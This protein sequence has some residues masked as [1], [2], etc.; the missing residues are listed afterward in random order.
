M[1]IIIECAEVTIS[2]TGRS[3]LSVSLDDVDKR[4]FNNE[5]V[6]KCIDFDVYCEAKGVDEVIAYLR[7]H[8]ELNED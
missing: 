5:E 3:V 6:A 2:K 1:D 4:D 8:Y 7:Q